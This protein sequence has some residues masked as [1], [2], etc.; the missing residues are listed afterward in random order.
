MAK[1]TM[2]KG[3]QPYESPALPRPELAVDPM[4]V[5]V[6]DSLPLVFPGCH[7]VAE[8]VVH[9]TNAKAPAENMSLT[10]F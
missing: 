8:R 1:I 9:P 10:M 4:I 2:Y 3:Y 6:Q 7:G 5:T